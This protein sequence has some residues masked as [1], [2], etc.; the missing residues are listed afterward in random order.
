MAAPAIARYP[1]LAERA[2]FISG[3][4]SGIGAAFVAQFAAQGCRV[5]FVD[6]ADAPSRALVAELGEERVRYFP[7][8]VRDIEALRAAIAEAAAVFGPV[9]VLVNNAARDDRHEIAEV[10]PEYWDDNFAVNLRHHFFAAQAVAPGMAAAGGGAIINLGSVAWLRGRPNL[11]A[12]ASAK[13]AIAG[14]TRVLAREYGERN[15]R[16]NSIMPG[17]VATARQLALWVTPSDEQR[18]LDSQCLKFRVS[19]DDVA[20]AALFLASAEARAITGQSL[21]VDA[22]LAQ[23]SF[24]P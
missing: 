3:G 6:I 13:A 18:Y 11:A 24:V 4:G 19:V 10:T 5:A 21:V 2:V 22:G 7:C 20:R 23:T 14:L 9:T 15:I 16:V 12:Y 8:D 17:A 1:D